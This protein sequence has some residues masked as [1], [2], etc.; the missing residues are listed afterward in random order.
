[1]NMN[2]RGLSRRGLLGASG[3]VVGGAALAACGAQP[4]AD[5]APKVAGPAT[6][7]VELMWSTEVTTQEFLEKDWIPNFKKENPGV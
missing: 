5:T 1:M 4:A 7:P 6:G 2:R 3:A